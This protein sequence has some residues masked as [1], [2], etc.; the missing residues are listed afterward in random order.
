MSGEQ[1]YRTVHMTWVETSTHSAF[2]NVPFDWRE[3]ST[4]QLPDAVA[5]VDGFEGVE[6]DSFEWETRPYDPDAPVLDLTT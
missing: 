2:V 6:R 3:D 4:E 5:D 1:Q